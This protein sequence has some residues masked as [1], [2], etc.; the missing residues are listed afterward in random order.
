MPD[1]TEHVDD[2]KGDAELLYPSKYLRYADLGGKD[3]TLT[4]ARAEKGH[5]LTMAGGVKEAKPVL[6]FDKTPKML[7][8]G[9]TN[10]RRV[11]SWHGS[12]CA[13]WAGKQITLYPAD[14][15]SKNDVL[16]VG[17]RG[18]RVRGKDEEGE[19]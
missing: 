18:V 6:H 7:V 2:Y 1:K 16:K 19:G 13:K 11:A 15:P 10:M 12:T 8:L 14:G 3:V 5:E 17:Q 9:K 4:I